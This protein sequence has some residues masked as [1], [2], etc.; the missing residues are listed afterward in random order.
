[1]SQPRADAAVLVDLVQLAEL[2]FVRQSA[3]ADRA[4]ALDSLLPEV[5]AAAARPTL[6]RPRVIHSE[7]VFLA[8]ALRALDFERRYGTPPRAARMSILVG[9]L[10]PM[11]RE[12]YAAALSAARQA[13]G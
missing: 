5:A 13:E 10:L 9:V 7:T 11:A 2:M 4:A 12:N 1:M 6:D 8:E 3:D